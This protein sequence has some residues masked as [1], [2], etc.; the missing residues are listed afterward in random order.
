MGRVGM[1]Q[2]NPNQLFVEYREQISKT[3]PIVGRRH[4]LTHS[5]VTGDLF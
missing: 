5:D 4:T 3:S 2:F 1:S